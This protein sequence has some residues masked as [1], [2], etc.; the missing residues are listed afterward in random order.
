MDQIHNESLYLNNDEELNQH[1]SQ[2]AQESR[3]LKN[4]LTDIF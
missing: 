3:K 4:T 2:I 1:P